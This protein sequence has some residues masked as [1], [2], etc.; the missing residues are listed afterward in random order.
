MAHALRARGGADVIGRVLVA[1]RAG[2]V[3]QRVGDA[4]AAAA[5]ARQASPWRIDDA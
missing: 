2:R 3:A 4:G 5:Q 1:L